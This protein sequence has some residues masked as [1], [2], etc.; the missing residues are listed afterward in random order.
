MFS[1]SLSLSLTETASSG[2]SLTVV[3]FHNFTHNT[4]DS[5]AFHWFHWFHYSNRTA[6]EGSWFAEVPLWL[7]PPVFL[8]SL[9]V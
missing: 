8:L 5:I 6:D 4:E 1:F 3:P 7:I 9:Q 2:I